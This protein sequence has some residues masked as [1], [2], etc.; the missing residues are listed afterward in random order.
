[1]NLSKIAF[2]GTYISSSIALFIPFNTAN[3]HQYTVNSTI[4]IIKSNLNTTGNNLNFTNCK[5]NLSNS[6]YY[7]INLV[8]Q[9]NWY[10]YGIYFQYFL[11]QA[12]LLGMNGL[13]NY[14]NFSNF[15]ITENY[16]FKV[17]INFFQVI[18]APSNFVFAM[19][20]FS[21]PCI[22]IKS[23]EDL[24]YLAFSANAFLASGSILLLVSI[25]LKSNA[26]KNKNFN[27]K[28]IKIDKSTQTIQSNENITNLSN[29]LLNKNLEKNN[30]LKVDNF[31]N[32]IIQIPETETTK[33]PPKKEIL[34]RKANIKGKTEKNVTEKTNDFD[35]MSAKIIRKKG[36]EK[37]RKMKTKNKVNNSIGINQVSDSI[38][39]IINMKLVKEISEREIQNKNKN[40]LNENLAYNTDNKLIKLEKD[41]NNILSKEEVLDNKYE[42]MKQK[43]ENIEY[44]NKAFIEYLKPIEII[45]DSEKISDLILNISATK[46]VM[47]KVEVIKDKVENILHEN[48]TIGGIINAIEIIKEPEQ[49]ADLI[50]NMSSKISAKE[51]FE[52]AGTIKGK[53]E[54]ILSEKKTLD[55]HNI[56][57]IDNSVQI[58]QQPDIISELLPKQILEDG[59]ISKTAEEFL[60][61]KLNLQVPEKYAD[62]I[63]NISTKKEI[64]ENIAHENQSMKGII[65]TDSDLL[66][67]KV[68]E[69]KNLSETI[70][71]PVIESI[72]TKPSQN[73]EKKENISSLNSCKIVIIGFIK[74]ISMLILVGYFGFSAYLFA[75]MTIQINGVLTALQNFA[76]I[77]NIIFSFLMDYMIIKKSAKV[78]SI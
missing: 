2:F 75:Y 25:Y 22:V 66:S 1:M 43:D 70:Y 41:P 4:Y 51:I 74:L 13:E 61:E 37:I 24:I 42:D 40:Y 34:E 58:S 21:L 39:N 33:L 72:Q 73:C 8:T 45:K 27:E 29:T 52:K 57:E 38:S 11:C 78:S 6:T 47:K 19:I 67:S 36:L 65:S 10:R 53:F 14:L 7:L 71:E 62:L 28:I 16:F 54:E 9:D 46:E 50:I 17:L 59:I 35:N 31:Y 26:K 49:I 15:K 5:A 64:V 77:L 68:S 56:K 3:Y 69:I 44:E 55:D 30:D 48:K 18:F 12:L 76:M 20:D 23:S 63:V 60:D 32:E